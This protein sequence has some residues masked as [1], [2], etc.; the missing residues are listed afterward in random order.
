MSIKPDNVEQNFVPPGVWFNKEGEQLAE[1]LSARTSD[2][3]LGVNTREIALYQPVELQTGQRWF[4][5][6][7]TQIPFRYGFR[8]VYHYETALPNTASVSVA[9]GI[10]NSTQITW[11]THVYGMAKDSAGPTWMPIPN[12]DLF[13]TVDQTNIN[14]TAAVDFSAY[15]E[16]YFVLEYLKQ[17]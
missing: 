13:I 1:Q 5:T 14:I 12:E 2:L 17:S 3:A 8:F 6:S 7:N 9:H 4:P 10:P 16:S 11:F 15:E